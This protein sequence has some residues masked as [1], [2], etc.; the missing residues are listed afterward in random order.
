[1]T[2]TKDKEI[3]EVLYSLLKEQNIEFFSYLDIGQLKV[4][5]PHLMPQN[6]KG[7]F[8]WLVPYYTGVHENR[9]V[10]LYAVSRDY[11]EFSRRTAEI[12]LPVLAQSFPGE[13]FCFFSDS[14]PVNEIDAAVKCGLGVY[15]KNRLL[16]NPKYGSF[17]FIA[18]MFTSVEASKS[19]VL[20]Y[21]NCK[22]LCL[23]CGACKAKCAFLRGETEVCYSELNQ[24]KQLTESELSEVKSRKLR[25]G[26]DDC[27]EVCP[28]N[29]KVPKTP[30]GFFYEDMRE[31]VTHE[32]LDS[33]SKQEF[34]QRAYSWRGK[35]VIY[36]NT[37]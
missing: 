22:R 32:Y 28:M 7:A 15:G 33:L 30:I 34:K 4:I 9:N 35:K 8:F 27:Q 29:K 5:Q 1:M 20:D 23:D 37:D 13:S 25:W 24:K 36:R 31:N 17:V 16:I 18:S 3:H 12:I 26:C 21:T 2:V 6:A 14:S 10:S 11:H 19:A